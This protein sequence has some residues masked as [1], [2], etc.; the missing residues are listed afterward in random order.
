[1]LHCRGLLRDR[2]CVSVMVATLVCDEHGVLKID[3]AYPHI[4]KKPRK[5]VLRKAPRKAAIA[6][7]RQASR[8]A[9]N[10]QKAQKGKQRRRH[11]ANN[12]TFS[13]SQLASRPIAHLIGRLISHPIA[14]P[15]NYQ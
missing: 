10:P 13:R 5:R 11:R 8:I 7:Q 1:M 4:R 6:G 15:I 9:E 3:G 14:Y 2:D 12:G